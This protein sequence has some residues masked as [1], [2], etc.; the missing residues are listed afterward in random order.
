MLGDCCCA[1]GPQTFRIQSSSIERHS[2]ALLILI[3]APAR[4]SG[5][6]EVIT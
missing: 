3:L 5:G 2:G 1:I 4:K 6:H